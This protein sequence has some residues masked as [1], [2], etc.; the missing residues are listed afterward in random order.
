[1]NLYFESDLYFVGYCLFS[2]NIL[3]K[4][5]PLKNDQAPYKLLDVH[6]DAGIHKLGT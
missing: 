3:K 4:T 6:L 1:M 5:V 2:P